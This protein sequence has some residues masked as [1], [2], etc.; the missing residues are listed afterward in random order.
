MS[1][2]YY[3]I[4]TPRCLVKAIKLTSYLLPIKKEAWA[5]R[6]N[7]VIGPADVACDIRRWHTFHFCRPDGRLKGS[8]VPLSQNEK[9]KKCGGHLCALLVTRPYAQTLIMRDSGGEGLWAPPWITATRPLFRWIKTLPTRLASSFDTQTEDENAAFISPSVPN[10]SQKLLH[11]YC[12]GL[13]VDTVV[14]HPALPGWNRWSWSP[15]PRMANLLKLWRHFR[16][17][18]KGTF[19]WGGWFVSSWGTFP[20]KVCKTVNVTAAVGMV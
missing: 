9:P 2:D 18:E 8:L 10:E 16:C 3:L 5:G 19:A 1:C 13:C 15:G 6:P 20:L 7:V 4:S 12:S 17:G 11:V 14:I